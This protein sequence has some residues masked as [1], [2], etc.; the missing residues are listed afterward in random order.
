MAKQEAI[1]QQEVALRMMS[2]SYDAKLEKDMGQLHNQ[3]VAF[4]SASRLPLPQVLLVLQI[5]IK[6]TVDQAHAKYLGLPIRS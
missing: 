6:E 4:I 5:L 2:E 1:Q 3:F